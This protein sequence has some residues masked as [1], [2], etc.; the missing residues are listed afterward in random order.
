[1][2]DFFF[3]YCSL[4]LFTL[5]VH[6]WTSK[7]DISQPRKFAS[8][9]EQFHSIGDTCISFSSFSSSF[10]TH[11]HRASASHIPEAH[12]EEPRGHRGSR[13]SVHPDGEELRERREVLPYHSALTPLSSIHLSFPAS[14]LAY[15]ED[16]WEVPPPSHTGAATFQLGLWHTGGHG[17]YRQ[18][19]GGGHDG[20]LPAAP[21]PPASG[22]EARPGAGGRL[23]QPPGVP[24]EETITQQHRLG[25]KIN[26]AFCLIFIYPY[27]LYIYF[28]LM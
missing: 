4:H 8:G 2:L 27:F 1:M 10:T 17:V 3:F 7:S 21:R 18:H 19:P 9:A 23:L 14:L 26:P 13:Q 20:G 25:K 22:Q 5:L 15:P 28:V 24:G 16:W 12:W 11:T 6:Q